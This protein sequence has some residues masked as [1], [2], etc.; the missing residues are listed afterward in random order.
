MGAVRLHFLGLSE[1]ET[2]LCSRKK[3]LEENIGS[4][5]ADP[6]SR[7]PFLD[8]PSLPR[9]FRCEVEVPLPCAPPGALA[10]VLPPSASPSALA[11]PSN[12]DRS[13]PRRFPS[14]LEVPRPTIFLGT[15]AVELLLP[16]VTPCTLAVRRLRVSLPLPR[17]FPVGPSLPQGFPGGLAAADGAASIFGGLVLAKEGDHSSF[18]CSGEGWLVGGMYGSSGGCCGEMRWYVLECNTRRG[19]NTLINIC[20]NRFYARNLI[21]CGDGRAEELSTK[22]FGSGR[23][24]QGECRLLG[25]NHEFRVGSRREVY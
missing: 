23:Y 6:L 8:G 15:L 12:L 21:F 25:R 17:A 10:E 22:V 7:V 18:S 1:L 4:C 13:H 5:E 19:R 2:G 11:I 14:D 3:L 20:T 24:Y 9:G 16:S